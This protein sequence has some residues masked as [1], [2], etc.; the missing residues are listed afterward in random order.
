VAVGRRARDV[1]NA[2]R[3]ARAGAV[4]HHERLLEMGG[5]AFA[6]RAQ[7][8]IDA[9]ARRIGNDEVDGALGVFRACRA[10]GETRREQRGGDGPHHHDTSQVVHLASE[11][12]TAADS[13]WQRLA[14]LPA[15]M[16]ERGGQGN[17]R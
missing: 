15:S 13:R 2:D 7:Q 12:A 17:G 16:A 1:S 11:C 5:E 14:S 6:E 9:A 10:G 3:A 4:R 8:Q